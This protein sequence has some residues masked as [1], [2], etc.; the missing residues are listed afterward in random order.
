MRRPVAAAEPERGKWV[1]WAF[2]IILIVGIVGGGYYIYSSGLI[3]GAPQVEIPPLEPDSVLPGSNSGTAGSGTDSA[4]LVEPPAGR[5]SLPVS[6]LTSPVTPGAAAPALGDSGTLLLRD[7]PPRSQVM[8]DSRPL[9]E[10]GAALR[11]PVGWHELAITAPG[12]PFFRDSIFIVTNDTLEFSPALARTGGMSEARR[13]QL[14]RLDCDNPGQ[15]N[16]Y[17]RACYDSPPLPIGT[18]RVPVPP[19]VSGTPSVVI[20]LVK[21]SLGGR[22]MAVRTRNPSN[23]PAFTR[24][25]EVFAQ[26]MEW[27]PARRDGQPVDGWTQAAFSPEAP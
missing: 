13:R 20:L 4:V 3:G 23:E 9:T 15:V 21:V 6:A 27:S 10:G 2:A 7:L 18:T 16:R 12:A 11:L 22:T 14:L 26:G 1:P 24:A 25:A 17:G 5:E 19:E 8:I